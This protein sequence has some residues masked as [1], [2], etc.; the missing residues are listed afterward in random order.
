M[1]EVKVLSSQEFTSAVEMLRQ[2]VPDHELDR[3][4]PNGSATVYTTMV[5]LWMMTLQRLGG[6]KAQNATV[7]DVLVHS[8]E[9]LPDNRRLRE[10]TLSETSGAY[11]G[12]RLAAQTEHGR[13]LCQSRLRL[14]DQ[15]LAS[16]V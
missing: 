3:L 1:S 16:V 6:G 11:A 10:G 5:T 7:K 13:V 15:H 14:A 9:L 8:R 12:A 2:L 4:Q